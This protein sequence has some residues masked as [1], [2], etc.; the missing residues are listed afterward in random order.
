LAWDRLGRGITKVVSEALAVVLKD[1][2]LDRPPLIAPTISFEDFVTSL[3][4]WDEK[5]STSPSGRHLGLYKGI[6]TAHIDSGAEFTASKPDT[7]SITEKATTLL[8]A[9]HAIAVS[10]AES[11]LYLNRWT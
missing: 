4:H 6:L 11:G 5:T 2:F 8:F 10:V 1:A 3:L 7:L 9:I